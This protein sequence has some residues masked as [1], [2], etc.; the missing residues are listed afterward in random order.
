[1]TKFSK[2]EVQ[3]DSEGVPITLC[4]QGCWYMVT[5]CTIKEINLVEYKDSR[6]SWKKHI[7][8]LEIKPQGTNIYCYLVKTRDGSWQLVDIEPE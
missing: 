4:W 1:M 5:N 6:F 2:V 8:E 3:T 7:Y